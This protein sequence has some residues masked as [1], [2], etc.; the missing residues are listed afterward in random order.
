ML[1][2]RRGDF[3]LA[4]FLGAPKPGTVHEVNIGVVDPAEID[5]LRHRPP[6]GLEVIDQGDGPVRVRWVLQ[7][8]DVEFRS[9]G[10]IAGRWLDV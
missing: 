3:V 6:D 9:S 10:Q 8:A 4:L 1:A 2:L 5:S 7:R